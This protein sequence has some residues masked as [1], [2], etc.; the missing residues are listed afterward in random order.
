[1]RLVTDSR[2]F[3][4]ISDA[5]D[6]GTV[7]L[8]CSWY[9]LTSTFL[10]NIIKGQSWDDK[11]RFA[12]EKNTEQFRQYEQACDRVKTFY[13]EQHGMHTTLFEDI[14]LNLGLE[15]QTMEYNIRVRENHKNTV[16]ARMGIWEAMEKLNEL[17]DDSDPDVGILFL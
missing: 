16:H 12:D 15:K 5:V 6:E 11:P 14:W 3:D 4:A 10:V 13:K 7:T 2:A 1:M 8:T 9:I 17:I